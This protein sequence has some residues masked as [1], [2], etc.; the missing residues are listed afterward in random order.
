LLL[1]LA[2]LGI[3]AGTLHRCLERQRLNWESHAQI[4]EEEGEFQK[5]YKISRASFMALNAKL[6]PYLRVEDRQSRYRV[7]I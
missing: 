5:C 1:V 2:L 6:E 3:P 7:G 4:L